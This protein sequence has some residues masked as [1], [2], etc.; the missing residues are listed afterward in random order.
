MKVANL[1]LNDFTNDSRVLKTSKTLSRLGFDVTVVAL[2]EDG[3][4]IF[5]KSDLFNIHRMPLYTKKWSKH[6]IVQAFK[7]LEFS[8]RFALNYRNFD[9]LHCND[10]HGL[11]V[12]GLCKFTRP[13]I[14]I[15]YDSHEYAINDVP[16][17]SVLSIK[18]KYILER[19]FI[20]F[21][22]K[23]ITVS[24]SIANEY[25]RIYSIEKPGVV[26]NC[27]EYCVV[28]KNDKFR[29]IF[30]IRTD[31]K[32]FLY[33]GNLK[34]GRGIEFLLDVFSGFKSDDIVLVFMG[35]GSLEEWIFKCSQ[36]N[37]K[38]FLH[39]AVSHDEL[40][41]YTSSA[42]FGISFIEDTCLSYR[43]CLPN[44]MFEYIMA[45]LPVLT[46]NLF[47]M[48]RFVDEEKV[49]VVAE[50]NTEAGF[51]KALK[52][53]L[54]L[55]DKQLTKNIVEVRKRYNW[56]EQEKIIGEIYESI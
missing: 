33:Q 20:K 46:S 4:P 6:K 54:F 7:F 25:S 37:D 47:E 2:H 52:E 48:K 45:G 11:I 34:E 1:V 56:E 27:P 10:L 31:Q 14:K 35:Y 19:I 39:E 28:N 36:D 29:E 8:I 50:E 15:V 49:G 9:I 3:L 30:D 26:L 32:I 21:S 44:K 13:S 41:K 43:Y 22:K 38:I 17:E 16:G 51:F 40:L 12:G 42:D 55:D 53:L 5:D 24:E 18:T 23:V